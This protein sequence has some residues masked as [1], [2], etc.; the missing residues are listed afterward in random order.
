[1][2]VF[3][4]LKYLYLTL[5]NTVLVLCMLEF[6]FRIFDVDK[7]A[8]EK[9]IE[10][11]MNDDFY[12]PR[13][14]VM[15]A[16]EPGFKFFSSVHNILGYRDDIPSLPKPQNEFRVFILGGSTVH[17]EAI[18]LSEIL[19]S[20]KLNS[21]NKQMRFYNF[22]AGSSISRQD[23]MRMM[24]D[25]VAYE[26][27]LIIHY[28]GGN[29][30]MP[31]LDMRINYP[32]RYILFEKNYLL[33]SKLNWQQNF[34]FIG[35]HSSLIKY[36]LKD[37]LEKNITS[38]VH[39]NLSAIGDGIYLMKTVAYWANLSWMQSV[40]SMLQIPFFAVQQPF[41]FDK[42][43][44]SANELKIY[45]L[46]KTDYTKQI[47]LLKRLVEV[48]KWEINFY[49]CHKVFE[50]FDTTADVFRDLIH[51]NYVGQVAVA[52]CIQRSVQNFLQIP[53]NVILKN[54]KPILIPE[55]IFIKPAFKNQDQFDQWLIELIK[56]YS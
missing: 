20:K 55:D 24:I 53:K 44:Q 33:N 49:D 35:A 12:S 41:I 56:K 14:F 2:T 16:A 15:S 13:P 45:Q 4:F 52:D 22:G 9:S 26:P 6:G 23:F 43:K 21:N 25:A 28:G 17:G 47:N 30:L 10:Y 27:D 50:N 32:H 46:H 5:I 7:S 48:K 39:H 19:S 11:N 37:W 29:D 54:T 8:I 1:M 40:S 51:I 36:F 3:R 38:S 31:A 42:E 34:I 18:P